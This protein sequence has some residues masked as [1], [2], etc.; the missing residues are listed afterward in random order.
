M[1]EKLISHPIRMIVGLYFMIVIGNAM[2]GII[3]DSIDKVI[4]EVDK[5][6]AALLGIL[7]FVLNFGGAV[8]L[9]VFAILVYF[10]TQWKKSE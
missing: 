3:N 8:T 9:S 4:P 5:V 7:R 1:F 2:T 6:S 10:L